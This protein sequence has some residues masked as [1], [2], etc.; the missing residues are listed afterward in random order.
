MLPAMI[1][2]YIFVREDGRVFQI[3]SP[4]T[5]EDLEHAQ[6]GLV[7]I[8]RTADSHTYGVAGHWQPISDGVVA[9]PDPAE[10]T[11]PPYHVPADF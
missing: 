5:P 6:A 1:A 7:T 8:L 11:S 4:P 10:A 3:A 2:P 9:R